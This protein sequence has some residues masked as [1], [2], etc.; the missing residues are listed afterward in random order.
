MHG[1]I[2]GTPLTRETM[3]EP[4]RAQRIAR[5]VA[6]WHRIEVP[7]YAHPRLFKTLRKWLASVP[8]AYADPARQAQWEASGCTREWLILQVAKLKQRLTTGHVWPVVFCHNDLLSANIIDQ[9]ERGVAFIDYEYGAQNFR[10]FDIGNHFN[11]YA[12]FECRFEECYP[13]RAAQLAWLRAYLEASRDTAA[14]PVTDDELEALYVEANAFT[15]A[16]HLFWGLWALIQAD[17]SDI[18]FD[19]VGYAVRRF[20][21][22]RATKDHWLALL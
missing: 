11:E 10:G 18:A 8:R 15:L 4:A 6:E 20:S 1:Y 16:S 22:Y 14:R 13:G 3:A 17:V 19:Y 12:G 2:E 5:R 21:R 7:G 9:G